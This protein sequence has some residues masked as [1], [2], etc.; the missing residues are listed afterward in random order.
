MIPQAQK[1]IQELQE[2]G[3][4]VWAEGPHG[5]IGEDGQPVTLTPWQRAILT[6]YWQNRA[7]I[8]TLAISNVKKTGKTFL[9]A[10][11]LCFR[12]LAYPGQHFAAGNDLDQSQARQFAMIVE[13]VRNNPFLQE[14]VKIGKTELEF[15]LTGSKLTA[16]STDARGNSGSN[17]STASHT[18]AWG[19]IYETG[20]RSFE[21]LTPPPGK[22]YGLPALRICDSY[23]GFEG[24]SKIW[25]EMVDRGLKGERISKDWPIFK[26][27]GLL[28]FHAE[29][30]WAREHCFRGT[31]EEA[32]AY[33]KEQERTLRTNAFI[34]MHGNQRTSGEAAFVT[35]EAWD[36]CYSPDIR[37]IHPKDNRPMVL[38]AD[39]STSHDLTALVGCHFNDET[40][41]VEVLSARVWK[42]VKLAGIRFGKP[43]VDLD[44]TIG[45]AVID[46]YNQGLVAAVVCDPFQLHTLILKWQK[47]G[48]RVIE[49]AQNAGR[50]EADQSLYTAIMGRSIAHYN[51]P[52]LNEH[53]KNAVAVETPRGYRLAK[54]K[55]SL[56]IDA[57]VALSMAHWGAL[58]QGSLGESCAI[59]DPTNNL[60]DDDYPEERQYVNV[61]PVQFSNPYEVHD[62]NSIQMARADQIGNFFWQN[63]VKK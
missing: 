1:Y 35:P 42:P 16:L 3:P 17:F 48:I 12:W 52:V 59:R 2:R 50:V 6:A 27:G 46:L 40:N 5:W 19:V 22:K 25:H 24:E 29:G 62:A 23:A 34:R 39:A 53:V 33:Y 38:G 54:E 28:L 32:A 47:A 15:T 55:A 11:L 60:Y 30:Q 41:I 43:T 61:N 26:D 13:M 36:A 14:N 31:P 10:V 51:D 56:K 4:V 7:E 21:E 45:Q 49:L 18:E 37:P 63:L 57:A 20:I 9:N 58:R 8:S 44:E